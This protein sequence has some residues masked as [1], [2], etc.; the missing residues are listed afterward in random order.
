MNGIRMSVMILFFMV[1]SINLFAQKYQMLYFSGDGGKG[2][3][4]SILEPQSQG[5]EEKLDDYLPS[6]VQGIL[7]STISKYSAINVVDR[8]S[9]EKAI[10]ESLQGIYTDDMD[11]ARL[12]HITQSGYIMDSRITRISTGYSL[13]L[14]VNDI[15]SQNAKI[16]A[17]YSGTCTITQIDDYSIIHKACKELLPQMGVQLTNIAIAEMDAKVEEQS[18]NAQIAL[19]K[20]LMAQRNKTDIAAMSYFF[21]AASFDPT[22]IEAT[23]RSS[24]MIAN[25]S[26]GNIEADIR[27][28]IAWRRAWVEKLT[29]AEEFFTQLLNDGGFYSLSY[30]TSLNPENID[31]EKETA[32]ISFMVISQLH[33]EKLKEVISSMNTIYRALLD[34]LDATGR[35][36]QWG[37]ASWP[38]TSVTNKNPYK[39]QICKFEVNFELINTHNMVISSSKY[40]SE[41]M[42]FE[43]KVNNTFIFDIDEASQQYFRQITVDDLSDDLILRIVSVNGEHPETAKVTITIWNA[44]EEYKVGGFGPAWGYIFYDKGKYTNGWRFLEAAPTNAEFSAEWGLYY[45]SCSDTKTGIGTGKANTE[46]IIRQ[47]NKKGE[48]QKAAQLCESLSI[49]GFSDWFLPSKDELNE[50]Y[51]KLGQDTNLGGFYIEDKYPKGYYWSS[52]V[53]SLD[54]RY[55]TWFQRF[56]DG[57]Q[58]AYF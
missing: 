7:V 43:R 49:N 47:L 1:V 57:H 33:K 42:M 40:Y 25:I 48:R 4:L 11:I 55:Y 51:I 15:T 29:E 30:T 50:I 9:L 46:A 12:G 10:L 19:A 6:L 54:K 44:K 31:Y 13:Q 17:S 45:V 39:T 5:L 23:T 16:I 24:I 20:G 21:T 52:S 22:L 3:R 14:N 18:R 38:T 36:N 37:L 28:D 27:N 53:G 41:R 8:Q 34:G 2:M 58:F 56:S 35:K 32:D 26:S